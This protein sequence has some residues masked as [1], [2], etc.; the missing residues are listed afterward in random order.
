LSDSAGASRELRDDIQALRGVA[1]LLV[2]LQH[3]GL[4]ILKAGYLGVDIFFVVSGY[5]VA[6]I[7]QRQIEGGRF[8]FSAFYLRR[9]MRLLP[10]AYAVFA[11][12][13][14][15]SV[16]FL[17]SQQM[18]DYA[19]QLLGALSFTANVALYFQSGYFDGEAQLKPL[20][21]IWSLGIEEQFYL[22]LPA[23]LAFT[24]QR[25]WVPA[26][27]LVFIGSLALC[28]AFVPD[29]PTAAFYLL[30]MRA[31]E[32]AL[33]VLGALAFGSNARASWLS[34]AFW[35]AV[36]TLVV[37][38][39]FPTGAPHP[40]LDALL[41]DVATLVVILRRHPGA[42]TSRP[43]RML[44]SIGNW[45]YSL[46]LV[47]WPLFAY[48]NNAYVDGVPWYVD[49]G[50][51]VAALVLGYG[52]HR[53]VEERWRRRDFGVRRTFLVAGGASLLILLGAFAAVRMEAGAGTELRQ[54]RRPNLGFSSKCEFEA[55]FEPKSSCLN[56]ERPQLMVWGD[57]YAMHLVPGI[58]AS[59]KGG[60]VQATKTACG[61]TPALVAIDGK[62][63]GLAWASDCVAFNGSVL[64]YLERTPSVKVVVL[65]SSFSQY[66]PSTEWGRRLRSFQ[67]EA[68]ALRE[69]EGGPDALL[70]SLRYAISHIRDMGK[71]VVVVAPPPKS[72]L[73]VGEC[74]ERHAEGKIL[75][76]RA[77]QGCD[78]Q[79]REYRE[80]QAPVLQVLRRLREEAGV[81]VVYLDDYLCDASSCRSSIGGLPVYR[82]TGHL[83]VEASRRIGLGMDLGGRLQA[84]AR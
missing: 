51:C 49:A 82:D 59:A 53:G 17:T 36:A 7:L 83:T 9:V 55:E 68:G 41:V 66:L 39:F 37:V 64:A 35:P 79:L 23:A 32:L 43:V 5:L 13:S 63:H 2:L 18:R 28:L 40:G 46:Y 56:S 33:G 1:I 25:Y 29:R 48:A 26:T 70:R 42:G 75:L 12:T 73:D 62:M 14:L 61:P 76:G 60:V 8:S 47:H 72:G 78:I 65:S 4:G 20:L 3:S 34:P 45:S 71:R 11:V 38:P 21:H 19:A 22:L 24:R 16:A 54:A 57:S 77:R 15:A 10:A 80:T 27:I 69:T 74:L 81:E 31:W 50:L 67:Q 6:G 52:L 44:A 84:S 30:P 58:V